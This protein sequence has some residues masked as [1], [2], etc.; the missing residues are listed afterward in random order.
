MAGGSG[1][2]AGKAFVEIGILDKTKKILKA[3]GKRIQALGASMVRIGKKAAMLGAAMLAAFVVPIKAAASMQEVMSKF[4]VVFGAAT[5][6]V[7]KFG[8]ELADRLGRSKKQMLEFLAGAQDLLVPLGLSV[9]V[10]TRMSKAIAELAVDL[11]SFNEKTDEMAFEDLQSALTG[12]GEVMKKYGVVLNETTVKQE[13][14][15]MGIDP[16]N[17]TNAQK[18][19]ARYA[20]IVRGVSNAQGD[21]T[22]T[23]GSFSNQIKRMQGLFSDAMVE[24]G[25]A[26]LPVATKLVNVLNT[27]LTITARFATDFPKVSQV[28]FG[29]S[30]VLAVVGGALVSLGIFMIGA[31]AGVG[32]LSTAFAALSAAADRKSVV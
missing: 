12:S 13:L 15:N 11:A 31:T 19:L 18:V 1:I 6:S 21:A 24:I 14:F 29:L 25:N 7:K 3:I 30:A 2:R 20:V 9:P 10:A 26:L 16:K 5:D 32:A 8:I 23:A 22:E 28:V 17:A 27:V 4:E